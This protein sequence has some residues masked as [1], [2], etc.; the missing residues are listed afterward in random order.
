MNKQ[1]NFLFQLHLLYG[2]VLD[3]RYIKDMVKELNCRSES[4]FSDE[5]Q[6]H[7][8]LE[9]MVTGAPMIL[10]GSANYNISIS[11]YE[12][13]TAIAISDYYFPTGI[14]ICAKKISKDAYSVF[15]SENEM[16][17]LNNYRLSVSYLWCAKEAIAKLLR[18]GIFYTDLKLYEVNKISTAAGAI[19]Q[20][21]YLNF[22][23]IST[24]AV[25]TGSITIA[26]SFFRNEVGLGKVMEELIKILRKENV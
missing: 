22:H 2:Q 17:L 7:L 24:L 3:D 14:D 12:K 21:D 8:H 15:M 20:I 18:V 16:N 4:S 23:N 6:A 10:S 25:D 11:Y 19:C 26:V 1:N 5:N 13:Y 9:H